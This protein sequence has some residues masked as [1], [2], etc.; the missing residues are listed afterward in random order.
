[1]LKDRDEN[2]CTLRLVFSIFSLLGCSELWLFYVLSTS[3]LHESTTIVVLH[4]SGEYDCLPD[5][6][7]CSNTSLHCATTHREDREVVDLLLQ[8][9]E[10]AIGIALRNFIFLNQECRAKSIYLST[11]PRVYILRFMRGRYFKLRARPC[12]LVITVYLTVHRTYTCDII[13][14]SVRTLACRRYF[15][16]SNAV[17]MRIRTSRPSSGCS[18]FRQ[19]SNVRTAKVRRNFEYDGDMSHSFWIEDMSGFR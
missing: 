1:M 7:I 13:A 6:W 16:N 2:I 14:M 11:S 19:V 15:S 12:D 18:Q 4:K 3:P 9:L 10:K 8:L 17:E 5:Y